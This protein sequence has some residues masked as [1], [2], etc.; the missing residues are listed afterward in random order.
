LHQFLFV[1]SQLRLRAPAFN[2]T[3]AGLLR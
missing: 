2:A 3:S 1:A